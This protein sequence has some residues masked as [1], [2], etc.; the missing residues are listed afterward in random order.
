MESFALGAR[1]RLYDDRNVGSLGE[2]AW[3][4]CAGATRDVC[5]GLVDC[6]RWGSVDAVDCLACHLL[7]TLANERDPRRA[8]STEE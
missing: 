7:E 3:I 1:S 4:V 6:P 2:S 8:C 5:R